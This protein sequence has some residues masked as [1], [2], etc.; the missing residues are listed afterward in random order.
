MNK[1]IYFGECPLC[2]QGQLVAVKNMVDSKILL[3][4]DDCESQWA[5]PEAAKFGENALKEEVFDVINAS[6]ED[7]IEANWNIP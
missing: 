4:C 5:S 6:A 3:M 7:V 2:R 1:E